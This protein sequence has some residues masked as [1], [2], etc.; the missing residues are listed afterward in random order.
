MNIYRM[1][2]ALM[3]IFVC[4]LLVSG[5]T[6][7]PVLDNQTG[8]FTSPTVPPTTQPSKA[9]YKVTIAQPNNSR[10]DFIKMDSDV[11]NQGEVI[12]FYVVNEGTETLT[13][14]CTPPL[15]VIYRQL[16]DKSWGILPGTGEWCSFQIS[17]FKPGETTR[18]RRLITNDWLPGRY[19]I[20]FGCGI[21][22]E[23]E[24]RRIQ[25]IENP[26]EIID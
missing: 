2:L 4:I 3:M 12:E 16:D 18:V 13:C 7:K 23:F 6:N 10:A 11:Y 5:C 20:G 24:I 14:G 19:R 17:Y 9:L 21:S 15:F 8:T 25:K 22:R 26:W 1:T